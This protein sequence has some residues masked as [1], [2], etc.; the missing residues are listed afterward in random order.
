VEW[1]EANGKLSLQTEVP[2]GVEAE[3]VLDRAPG[4][5]QVL[6]HAGTSTDLHDLE[7]VA[8][9]GLLVEPDAVRIRVPGGSHTFELTDLPA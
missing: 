3:V 6:S 8:A 9:R 5:Q 2:E 7:A 4:R 1:K